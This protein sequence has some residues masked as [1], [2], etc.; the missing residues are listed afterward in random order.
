MGRSERRERLASDFLVVVDSAGRVADFH[1]LRASYI[2]LLVMS[3]I[4]VKTAQELARHSDPKLTMNVYT[5]LGV[6][7][8][9]SALNALPDL[10]GGNPEEQRSE[11][12]AT[13]SMDNRPMTTDRP[14]Q[15][16]QQIPQQLGREAV[17]LR[18]V[19]RMD[20]DRA[21]DADDSAGPLQT[22]GQSDIVR[23]NAT[24]GE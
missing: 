14:P 23:H 1:A 4:S 11:L 7:D 19:P 21:L 6:H 17:R 24:K 12:R 8:L 16:P 2:T 20:G 13:G 10:G 15:K 18:A 3:G 9:A 5:R 22:A